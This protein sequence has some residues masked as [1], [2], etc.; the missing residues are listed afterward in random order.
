MLLRITQEISQKDANRLRAAKTCI[1]GISR[2]LSFDFLVN[3]LNLKATENATAKASLARVNTYTVLA[4]ESIGLDNGAEYFIDRNFGKVNFTFPREAEE[5]F[6]KKERY[7]QLQV[8]QPFSPASEK[9]TASLSVAGAQERTSNFHFFPSKNN[10]EKQMHAFDFLNY[11]YARRNLYENISSILTKNE[12]KLQTLTNETFT[13]DLVS[14]F[15]VKEK[16]EV[17]AFDF[18]E[19]FSKKRLF[20]MD[21]PEKKSEEVFLSS[22]SLVTGP[23]SNLELLLNDENL[24]IVNFSLS[25][26]DF[27]KLRD[28]NV[29]VGITDE[30]L[31]KDLRADKFLTENLDTWLKA[32]VSIANFEA[33]LY[34]KIK[35]KILLNSI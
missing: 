22:F 16:K 24:L 1:A 21:F 13:Q 17:A 35:T 26:M 15:S 30:V 12:E 10:I 2:L 7:L 4:Q 3:D 27:S 31:K 25:N 33:E 34:K 23:I 19:K 6:K 32:Y 9:L 14:L 11:F 20:S 28:D 29:F 18:S 5:T 8:L